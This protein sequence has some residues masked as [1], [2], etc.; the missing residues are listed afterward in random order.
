MM[1]EHV[2]KTCFRRS[3][4][5]DWI[6]KAFIRC[7]NV[8]DD[9]CS[10]QSNKR[11]E[12]H[13]ITFVWITLPAVMRFWKTLSSFNVYLL[14]TSLKMLGLDG[15]VRVNSCLFPQRMRFLLCWILTWICFV[16]RT[17]SIAWAAQPEQGDLGNPSP[18]S[19]SQS[20]SLVLTCLVVSVI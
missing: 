5:D 4:N 16:C 12:K 6:I 9:L 8:N 7:Y 2:K 15:I 14:F 11:G 18:S 10:H 13:E 17:T 3:I 20:Q 19:H 1:R